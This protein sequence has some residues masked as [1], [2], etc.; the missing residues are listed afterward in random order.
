MTHSFETHALLYAPSY[1]VPISRFFVPVPIMTDAST[2]LP[3]EKELLLATIDLPTLERDAYLEQACQGSSALKARVQELLR[4][5][6][7]Q[8][9]F[10][11][12]PALDLA[13]TTS[14][15]VFQRGTLI[16]RYR[17]MEQV[18]E[19]GM[20]VVFVAEQT[21]PVRRKVA[22][23]VI[24][25]GMDSKAVIARF[26][27]ERQALA[28]MDHPNIARVLDGGTT[29]ERLPYFV[30]EL[31]RGL[32]ITT[33]CDQ[34]K[35]TIAERLHLFIDVC[36]AV[37]HAHQ[38]GVIHRDLKPSNIL[39][40]L[41]DGKP[42]V[43]V[44][45]FGVAK[46]LHQPLTQHTL[47]TAFNQVV[48]TP[49]YM[50]PEQMELSGLDIDTRTDVY[51]L[52]ILLYELLAG[53]TPFDRERLLRS[54]FDEL[55]RI[56][57]EEDPPRPSLRVT[58]MPQAELST[59]T[60]RR[61]I[62][63]RTLKRSMES[64]LDW[65]V[66]K[67]L[68]KDRRRRY[69]SV[70][71]FGADV[72][73]FLRNE[74]V[75]ACPPSLIYSLKKRVLKHRFA[76]AISVAVLMSLCAG[77]VTTSWQWRRALAAEAKTAEANALANQRADLAN[78]RLEMAE[79][80]IEVMYAEFAKEWLGRQSGVSQR[81]REFLNKA[82]ASF[83]QLAE[84]NPEDATPRPGAIR[85]N[86][87]SGQLL[88]ELGDYETALERLANANAMAIRA[89][90]A[91]PESIELRLLIVQCR[92]T[93]AA[94]SRN[95]GEHTQNIEHADAAMQILNELSARQGLSAEHQ[96]EIAKGF[97]NCALGYASE[98]SRMKEAEMAAAQGVRV[99]RE[100]LRSN[101]DNVMYMSR[102][103]NCLSAKGQQALWWGQDNEACEQAYA[104]SIALK[105]RLS[106]LAP[107]LHEAVVSLPSTLQNYGVV[108]NRL[109]R[110]EEARQNVT[111]R[112]QL[113]R[114]LV[115]RFP[116]R[117]DLHSALGECLRVAGNSEQ[118]AGRLEEAWKY[119]HEC[120]V[121]LEKTVKR[122]PDVR[123][124]RR[125]LALS[126]QQ[127][128]SEQRAA[129]DMEQAR[130]TLQK[131]LDYLSEFNQ[132][133]P[134]DTEMHIIHRHALRDRAIIDLTARQ[135]A[136][137]FASATAILESELATSPLAIAANDVAYDFQSCVGHVLSCSIAEQIAIHCERL[138]TGDSETFPR[139]ANYR[140]FQ[141]RCAA[142]REVYL[143]QWSS[144]QPDLLQEWE[145]L[146]KRI[147]ASNAWQAH[148]QS[149]A[150]ERLFQD[151]LLTARVHTFRDHVRR[152]IAAEALP[153][154]WPEVVLVAASAPE[155]CQPPDTLLTLAARGLAQDATSVNARRGAAWLRYRSGELDR[156]L[157]E[158][159]GLG[160]QPQDAFVRAMALNQL[161]R[162]AEALSMLEEAQAFL[163]SQAANVED[164]QDGNSARPQPNV[165]TYRRLNAEAEQLLLSAHATQP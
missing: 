85:A 137:A 1:L 128:S 119:W 150:V 149:P 91:R 19:G 43:K 24:K 10:M 81:Q 157:A 153:N 69:A 3:N 7:S 140:Q 23:K 60:E 72:T 47:Y 162:T 161:Q 93:M 2:S 52:G 51:S 49:L 146:S 54:G 120:E 82:V 98:K 30:M 134:G 143:R 151:A 78:R 145:E 131:C 102:L 67:A 40:T 8:D 148:H 135:H 96:E 89:S 132:S 45:D 127:F 136:A 142:A 141:Q 66:L 117:P 22:L 158:L 76:F 73:R 68:E 9:S 101:P 110:T 114:E 15:D 28:L 126:L 144:Q 103:A 90:D 39:V 6:E 35:A 55:R 42:V 41:H 116:D 95:R 77:L 112:L 34:A 21:E 139:L 104:E 92:V 26:E 159:D 13:A 97:A 160:Q 111:E 25:P 115:I 99:A 48:G 44:I 5:V 163:S 20:G 108:L 31:V 33:Y 12:A 59:V 100:L 129:G 53:T 105:K 16:D 11:A 109:K 84:E 38:K 87:R 133:F 123:A 164:A 154:H 107:D 138:A 124:A 58:T 106:E 113:L 63:E 46:A 57:R 32:P 125:S 147:D 14:L 18:G 75:E 79:N 70:A 155:F 36:C 29:A 17:L 122:F 37:Q 118:R 121:L 156:C 71:D 64:E 56:I 83:Q 27:V 61:G 130:A 4:Q 74:M 80:A 152:I 62:D 88:R 50:S 65:I 165:E 86:L 94:I